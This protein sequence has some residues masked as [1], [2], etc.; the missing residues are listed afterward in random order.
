MRSAG[1]ISYQLV[2]LAFFMN[3]STMVGPPTSRQ[4]V[5]ED[6]DGLE[7]VAVAVDHRVIELRAHRRRLGILGIGH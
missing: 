3:L 2:S 7:P 1:A 4:E 5:E 6:R